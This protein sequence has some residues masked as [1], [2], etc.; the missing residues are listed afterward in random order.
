MTATAKDSGEAS[1]PRPTRTC[2]KCGISRPVEDFPADKSVLSGRRAS[3]KICERARHL[4]YRE[5]K[6]EK[7]EL[8]ANNRRAREA[9]DPA[10]AKA[11]W[12][13]GRV[14]SKDKKRLSSKAWRKANYEKFLAHKRAFYW[15]HVAR[16]RA[17]YNS[18]Q[19]GKAAARAQT[20]V[21]NRE[22]V[23]QQGKLWRKANPFAA[24]A[25][26]MR[27][28]ARRLGAD[29][30]FGR[31]D[32]ERIFKAQRGKCAYCAISVKTKCHIDHILPLAA[33]GSNFPANIQILCPTCNLR[34]G[35]VHPVEFA[36][37]IGK[38]L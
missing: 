7:A 31:E 18:P 19:T 25:I 34:K 33:G 32:I 1:C 30:S 24:R 35:A 16:L 29:G 12:K 38:L 4:A 27:R 23:A 17:E 26:V 10:A 11:K 13:A 21:R 5:V 3:C 6:P 9:A 8:Y 37:K 14:A 2:T 20:Y 22:I 15:R 28:R 36:Q